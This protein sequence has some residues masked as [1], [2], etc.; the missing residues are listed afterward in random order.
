MHGM[1]LVFLGAAA[2][3]VPPVLLCARLAAVSRSRRRREEALRAALDARIWR[4]RVERV[5]SRTDVSSDVQRRRHES[6]NALSTALLSA[7]FLFAVT[8]GERNESLV[9][10]KTAAAELVE[11]LQ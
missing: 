4:D 3:A 9:D 8:S 11:A 2:G 5:V 6:N 7:Q 1:A 10:Q